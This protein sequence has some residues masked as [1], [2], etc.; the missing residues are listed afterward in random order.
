MW[1]RQI[2]QMQHKDLESGSI[3]EL[4]ATYRHTDEVQVKIEKASSLELE[5]ILRK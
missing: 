4:R 5:R 3:R 1:R 2:L